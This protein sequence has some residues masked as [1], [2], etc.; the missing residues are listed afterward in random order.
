MKKT[1]GLII[2]GSSQPFPSVFLSRLKV[3][4][5]EMN[6]LQKPH[7][8]VGLQHDFPQEGT[9]SGATFALRSLGRRVHFHR[10]FNLRQ[11]WSE[12]KTKAVS[13]QASERGKWEPPQNSV[14]C[15]PS[16]TPERP[17]PQT[18]RAA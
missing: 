4:A 18:D 14:P 5:I 8:V 16:A 6:T 17:S 7:Q 2:L 1:K 12:E 11:K 9:D 15:C 10:T 3:F 13:Q